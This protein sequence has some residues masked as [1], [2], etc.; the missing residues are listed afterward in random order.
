MNV[1]APAGGKDLRSWRIRTFARLASTSDFC[2]E[3][4]AAGE[5]DGLAVVAAEQSA[6]RGRDARSWQS[7]PGNLFLSVL[8]RPPIRTE[9][10]GQYA[11]LTGVAVWEALAAFLPDP[12]ALSL[13]WPN[14]LLLGGRK[15]AG[16]LLES[17]SA[18]D[19]RLAWLVIGI[20]ANLSAA[21]SVP[22]RATACLADA[23]IAPPS[24]EDAAHAVLAR[25]AHWQARLEAEGF[26]PVRAAWLAHAHPPGASL[27]FHG[28][29]GLRHGTFAGLTESG[30][31]RLA[32]E[33]GTKTFAAGEVLEELTDTSCFS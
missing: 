26:A 30:A 17:A 28:P 15:L 7:P 22:G 16:I 3:R 18:A 10:A 9:A 8:L 12:A 14:D 5:P 1:P 33:K 24:T 2:R 29:T 21:P 4:A 13:K 19:G 20:G 23:A 31:L 27:V 11:L 6:G 25:L 32:T